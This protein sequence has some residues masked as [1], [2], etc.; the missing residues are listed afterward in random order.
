MIL[1]PPT[2]ET[3]VAADAMSRTEMLHYQCRR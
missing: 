2:G 3:G 1:P